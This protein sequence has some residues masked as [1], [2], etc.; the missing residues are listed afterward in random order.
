MNYVDV[1]KN[2]YRFNYAKSHTINVIR[3]PNRF[4]CG[5]LHS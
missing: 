4:G 5:S 2:N 3:I 1:I